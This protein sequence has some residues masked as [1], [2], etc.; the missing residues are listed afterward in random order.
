MY[1]QLII[2]LVILCSSTTLARE[3]GPDWEKKTFPNSNYV[4][5]QRKLNIV[6]T[7]AGF[8]NVTNYPVKLENEE[9]L[10]Y[11]LDDNLGFG[12][13]VRGFGEFS[14]KKDGKNKA[15]MYTVAIEN[16]RYFD[17]NGDGYFD[18][19]YDA[20]KQQ[21]EILLNKVYTPVQAS[22]GMGSLLEKTS[23]DGKTHYVFNGATWAQKE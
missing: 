6:A 4:E 20:N 12:I 21:S 19:R 3:F 8:G 10:I 5:Y 1:K 23:L 14:V 15:A 9:I 13:N 18:S 2:A 22:K 17:L 11:E 16:L 7:H